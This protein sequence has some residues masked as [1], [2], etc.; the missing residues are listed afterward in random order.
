MLDYYILCIK[1][2]DGALC[3]CYIKCGCISRFVLLLL[4]LSV[5]DPVMPLNIE[6]DRRGGCRQIAERLAP[7][8]ACQG[9]LDAS[10]LEQY[11]EK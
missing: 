5:H 4:R 9:G 7:F 2:I 1:L 11:L 3:E 6:S 8:I 10:A